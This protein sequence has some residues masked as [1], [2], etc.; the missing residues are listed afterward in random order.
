MPKHAKLD[1]Q[2][3]IY[4][5]RVQKSE[6]EKLHDLPFKKKLQYLYDYYKLIALAIIVGISIIVY[7]IY[8]IVTP[9]PVSQL[10]ISILNNTIDDQEIQTLQQE[11]AERMEIDPKTQE[12]VFDTSIFF[13]TPDDINMV[14]VVMT[15]L[16]VGEIDVLIAPKS[17][18]ENYAYNGIFSKTEDYLP[19]DLND[20]FK[21]YAYVTDL[22]DDP[23]NRGA[24]GIYLDQI[25]TNTRDASDPYIVGIVNG[26]KRTGNSLEFFRLLEE[27]FSKK[28]A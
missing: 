3:E 1:D 7:I 16:A 23:G 25:F 6:K 20:F 11:L 15:R 14:Q 4:Q 8:R 22:K 26:G 9:N 5:P 18:F 12:V 10:N 28:G 27:T 24:Y 2:A 13:S 21:D 19:S 17:L